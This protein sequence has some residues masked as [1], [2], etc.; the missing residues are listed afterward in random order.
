MAEDENSKSEETASNS[1]QKV[2]ESIDS[3]QVQPKKSPAT[4]SQTSIENMEVHHH[5]DIH[6]KRRKFRE[7]FFEF[8]MIFLAVTM[9]FLADSIR[10]H[11]TET[12]RENGFA[13]A[14]YAELNDD[15]AV[16]ANKF[17]IRLEKGKDLDYLHTFFTD[18]SLTSLPRKFYPAFTNGLYL[19]NTYAFEPKDGILSQL[20][21]SGSQGYFK[22][23]DLQKL[24]GD[25]SVCINNLRY[26]NEQEY[27]Y[28][29]S[30]LKPFLLKY[31][32][33][34]WLDLLRKKDTSSSALDVINAYR[35]SDRNIEGKILN[36]SSFDRIEASNMVLCYKQILMSTQ[37]LQLNNYILTNHKILQAL[38][39]N[40]E[41][42]NGMEERQ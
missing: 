13:K 3:S 36:I 22:N 4:D 21:N 31:F 28:F 25:I 34:N 7:Y 30:P 41:L 11:I 24:L 14:L 12:K 20:R 27:Q 38:R 5:P 10:E 23:M 17:A 26:R 8:I 16:A 33:F 35:L 18:S 42:E 6:H 2:P 37:T 32:D 15:S 9:G 39:E 29:A 19:I 1:P 40:Y